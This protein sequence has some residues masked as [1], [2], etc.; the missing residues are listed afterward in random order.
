MCFFA[1][2]SVRLKRKSFYH[3]SSLK[4]LRGCYTL[5]ECLRNCAFYSHSDDQVL[6]E[7][8]MGV[9]LQNVSFWVEH[10]AVPS[11]FIRVSNCLWKHSRAFYCNGHSIEV[12]KW[13]LYCNGHS[14]EIGSP[15]FYLGPVVPIVIGSQDGQS[16]CQVPPKCWVLAC[17]KQRNIINKAGFARASG[18]LTRHFPRA[19]QR[20][21]NIKQQ[22]KTYGYGLIETYVWISNTTKCELKTMISSGF[23]VY[24][25]FGGGLEKTLRGDHT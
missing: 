16:Y 11:P 14:I 22:K 4:T 2:T 7:F 21:L 24:D 15:A 13:A 23:A 10:Q 9:Q 3:A 18:H 1:I 19:V 12:K 25:T 5:I 8:P 17:F 20:S 6:L